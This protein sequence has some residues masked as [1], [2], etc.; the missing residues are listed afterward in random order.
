M[1]APPGELAPPPWGT[2]GFAT[3]LSIQL[4][5]STIEVSTVLISSAT[6]EY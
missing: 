4:L 3:D 1:L 2:P 5:V 6:G